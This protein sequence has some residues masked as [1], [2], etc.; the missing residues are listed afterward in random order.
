[1]LWDASLTPTRAK[2]SPGNGYTYARYDTWADGV[3][4]YQ[5]FVNHYA[6]TIDPRYS[7]TVCDT[8]D[9]CCARWQG[10]PSA[11]KTH[12]TYVQII[13]N[14][15][16]DEFEFVPG[17]FVETGDKMISISSSGITSTKR[18]FI[19]NGTPLFRGTNGDVLKLAAFA[20]TGGNCRFLGPVNQPWS[21][22]KW[23]W[24]AA[25]VNVKDKGE[26]VIYLQNPDKTEVTSA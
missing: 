3:V 6:V 7:A 23:A 14:L 25:I 22:T 16:N 2:Y 8:I 4:D 10:D 17:A 13:L 9:E 5:K 1:M 26:T 21:D 11:A 19:K 20:G 18:Y 24:A 12:D 15:I